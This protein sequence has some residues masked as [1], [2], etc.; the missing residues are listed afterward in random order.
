ME[1]HPAPAYR[2]LIAAATGVSNICSWIW[3]QNAEYLKET[4]ILYIQQTFLFLFQ[5]ASELE[6]WAVLR[7]LAKTSEQKW[8]VVLQGL[9]SARVF[10]VLLKVNGSAGHITFQSITLFTRKTASLFFESDIMY[11]NEKNNGGTASS[12]LDS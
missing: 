5:Y 3:T 4:T 11:H 7:I 9:T 2:Q 12:C 8:L 1:C 10:K 6:D